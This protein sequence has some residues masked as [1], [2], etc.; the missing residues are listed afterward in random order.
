MESPTSFVSAAPRSSGTRTSARRSSVAGSE[1]VA[2]LSLIRSR[3]DEVRPAERRQKVI[4]GYLVGQIRDREPHRNPALVLAA[5]KV[6][7]ADG[8][9]EHVPRSYPIRI[10]VVVLG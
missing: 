5:Q 2:D 7:G 9:I 4:Q 3:R 6:I 10:V 8:D 1:R